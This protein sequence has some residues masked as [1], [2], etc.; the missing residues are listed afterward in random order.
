[1]E[2]EMVILTGKDYLNS[3]RQLD[4]KL[5]SLEYELQC[6]QSDIQNLSA[7]DYSSDRVAGTHMSD[8]SDK[9][10][11]LTEHEDIINAE[12]DALIDERAKARQLISEIPD[13][14]KQGVLI[15]RYISCKNWDEI[16]DILQRTNCNKDITE[17]SV[18]RWHGEALITFEQIYDER[19]Q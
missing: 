17:R 15:L 9:I 7:V 1:M 6:I 11:K 2:S 3:L 19:C 8:L 14:R 4:V 12:W 13:Y 10:A 18:Q 16:A 5:R